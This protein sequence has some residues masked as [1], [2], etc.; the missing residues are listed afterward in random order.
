MSE[1]EKEKENKKLL[2]EIKSLFKH[3]S[4]SEIKKM[5]I[6]A[7][8]NDVLDLSK[9]EAKEILLE[10]KKF[11]LLLITSGENNFYNNFRF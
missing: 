7:I 4:E 10:N 11:N 6:L 2:I 9:I 8:I 1:L 5:P 3:S